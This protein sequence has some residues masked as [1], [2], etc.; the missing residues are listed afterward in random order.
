VCDFGILTEGLWRSETNVCRNRDWKVEIAKN[1]ACS[2]API[3]EI[4]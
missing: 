1:G 2:T 4:G 3:A